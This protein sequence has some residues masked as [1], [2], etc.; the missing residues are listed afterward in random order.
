[1]S[2][3]S[4]GKPDAWKLA[5]PV[6]GWGRGETPRPTPLAAFAGQVKDWHDGDVDV[7]SAITDFPDFEHLEA[8]GR[9]GK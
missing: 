8:R 4:S 6:W 1:M 3:E 9:A 7:E 5:S 2:T